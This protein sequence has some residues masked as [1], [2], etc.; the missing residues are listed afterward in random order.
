LTSF[1]EQMKRSPYWQAV[2]EIEAE[3]KPQRHDGGVPIFFITS[4]ESKL[5]RINGGYVVDCNIRNAAQRIVEGSHRLSTEEEIQK[6]YADQARR[7]DD[8]RLTE[9]KRKTQGAVLK[10]SRAD[11]RKLGEV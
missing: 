3:I 5:K 11:L 10:I 1:A 8:C 9:D 6:Y 2:H 4:V 7:S